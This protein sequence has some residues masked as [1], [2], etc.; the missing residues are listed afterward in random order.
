ME[1]IEPSTGSRHFN[2]RSYN[3]NLADDQIKLFIA[4]GKNDGLNP[5]K[6][7]EILNTEAKTPARKI[8]DI[9]ILDSFSFITVPFEEAESIMK[10]MNKEKSK[11]PLVTRAKK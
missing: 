8:R 1:L 7:L 9:K 11:R 3:T 5:R 2:E 10:A 4:M 6:L